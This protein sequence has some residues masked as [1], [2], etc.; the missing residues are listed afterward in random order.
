MTEKKFFTGTPVELASALFSEYAKQKKFTISQM[1]YTPSEDCE[2][3]KP[4]N[5]YFGEG[6][7]AFSFSAKDDKQFENTKVFS[8]EYI[9]G[10][11][12]KKLRRGQVYQ[13]TFISAYK[14]KNGQVKVSYPRLPGKW[15]QWESYWENSVLEDSCV[16]YAAVNLLQGE[17]IPK[18]DGDVTF[19]KNNNQTIIYKIPYAIE[20]KGRRYCCSYVSLAETDIV[21][22][23]ILLKVGEKSG[24][25]FIS[26]FDTDFGIVS[27]A[28][29]YLSIS[30][31]VEAGIVENDFEFLSFNDI[32]ADSA[33]A[34]SSYVVLD[35]TPDYVLI[36]LT[37]VFR[38]ET[39]S[40]ALYA[41]NIITDE[42]IPFLDE[43]VIGIKAVYPEFV[44]PA[45]K[46]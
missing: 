37:S 27:K 43:L 17:A 19:C 44:T 38:F 23:D 28:E 40:D 18:I 22:F 7:L 41:L 13:L 8:D 2:V 20:K 1:N 26:F 34:V 33:P 11:C 12:D 3:G 25:S 21:R 36:R 24:N 45:I 42:A 39:E 14:D 15:A 9:N 10:F 32:F 16:V 35:N 31:K 46:E 4:I 6:S 30:G 29:G 5:M